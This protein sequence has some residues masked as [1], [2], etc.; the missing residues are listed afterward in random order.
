MNQVRVDLAQDCADVLT[1]DCEGHRSEDPN[2]CKQ[3][4]FSCWRHNNLHSRR[5]Q[6]VWTMQSYG[7]TCLGLV[8]ST[9]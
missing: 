4:V 7:S 6:E 1:P 5:F 3:W 9:S 2:Q 8:T